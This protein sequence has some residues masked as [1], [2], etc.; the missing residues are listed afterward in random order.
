MTLESTL[1]ST[2][3]QVTPRPVTQE[4][5][6]TPTALVRSSFPRATGKGLLVAAHA[7]VLRWELALLRQEQEQKAA[8]LSI[9]R[10]AK[11]TEFG[12]AHDFANIRS[13]AD[14]VARVK[15]GDYD[16][17]SPFIDRMR[18]GE[19]NLLVPEFVRYYGNSSGSSNA[20]RQKFLPITDRQIALQRKGGTDGLMRA[21][22][23][24][25][26]DAFTT[27]FTLGLFPPTTMRKEG[28][29]FI[30]SNPALMVNKL[31]MV[32][33]PI[34]LP[35]DPIRRM[36]DYDEKLGAIASKYFEHDIRA[37]AGTTCW[38]T[39]LFEK[40]LAE[41]RRRGSRAKTI[42]EVWPN[43]R[44][45]LGGGVAADPYLP[46]LRELV[47][48]EDVLL[49]D[50]YNATEGGIYAASDQSGRPGM[51]VSPH[52]GTF[53]EFVEFGEHDKP[54]ARRV[55]L[56]DVELGKS[57]VIVVTTVSGLYAYTLGD[58]VRFPE[59][60]RME[61]VGRLSGCLSV[62]QELTTYVEVEKAMAFAT[63]KVPCVVVDFG[64]SAEIGTKSHYVVVAEFAPGKSPSD[65]QAL[66]AAFDEGL[67]IENRVYREHRLRDAAIGKPVVWPL[68]RG[69]AKKYLEKVTRGNVQGKFPRIVDPARLES[70]T[71]YRLQTH[72]S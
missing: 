19:K 30:T 43:L 71:P 52:R 36:V 69:G 44:Y 38:F 14:Y 18:K 49:V 35:D 61:F 17:F 29:V 42:R 4:R 39:L 64:V 65:M 27:G 9:V 62:T 50:S 15:V 51:L 10:H 70:L 55:P 11:D 37:V 13:H 72:I 57:Y 3:S 41:A 25:Q 59:R 46:V 21:L 7:Q 2:K 63:S 40:V 24:T 8:L 60:N 31:P 45:L 33:R 12:R 48:R 22:V 67:S 26:D 56:W 5:V 34:Y 68:Q 32:S 66:A 47:G 16:T 20:G 54:G 6:H 1:S 58:I 28:P 53:F 23:H